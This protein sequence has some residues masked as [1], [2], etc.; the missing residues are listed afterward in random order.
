LI[1]RT[2]CLPPFLAAVT[3]QVWHDPPPHPD[4]AVTNRHDPGITSL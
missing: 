4:D 3:Y 1:S 2:T